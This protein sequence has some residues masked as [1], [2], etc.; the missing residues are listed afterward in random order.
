MMARPVRRAPPAPPT[1]NGQQSASPALLPC[2]RAAPMGGQGRSD[3]SEN[4][5]APRRAAVGYNSYACARPSPAAALSARP[6]PAGRRKGSAC[7]LRHVSQFRV[8]PISF[9]AATRSATRAAR[10]R[11][12]RTRLTG[13]A[14]PTRMHVPPPPPPPGAC[15]PPF[16]ERIQAPPAA[17]PH[18]HACSIGPDGRPLRQHQRAADKCSGALRK[19]FAVRARRACAPE[20]AP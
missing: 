16:L 8:P 3:T 14:L 7:L 4:L 2:L 13:P 6:G 15:G 10:V 20:P 17:Y 9:S 11:G 19:A 5:R 1:R 12:G 18:H